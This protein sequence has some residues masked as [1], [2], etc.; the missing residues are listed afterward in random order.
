MVTSKAELLVRQLLGKGKG[1]G[2]GLSHNRP[3][4]RPKGVR[5]G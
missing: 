5:V 3:S 4:R 2:K 1:K